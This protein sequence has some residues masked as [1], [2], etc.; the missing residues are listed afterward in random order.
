MAKK[1]NNIELFAG[2]GG[3]LDGFEQT[4]NYNLL[5]AVEWL[6]PQ[7]RTLINRLETKYGDQNATNKILNFDIQRTDELLKGWENDDEFGTSKGLD[8]L[9]GNNSVDVISGGPPCQAYSLAGR[10]RDTNGMK[11]D[12]RNFLFEAY[13]K[14]VA[15]YRPKVIVF[16][17]VE[18]IL[19]AIPTGEKIIDLIR[20]S[21]NDIDYEIINDLRQHAL[22]DLTEYGVPQKRKRVIIVGVRK[23]SSAID[24]QC[25]LR[26]F[27]NNILVSMKVSKKNTVKDALA[28]LPP[29][30]PLK[31]QVAKKAY[32]NNSC[33]N[34][35]YSRFHSKRD[36]GIFYE[37]A[38]DIEIGENK[39]SNADALIELYYERTGKKTNVHK[40]HV[41]RWDEPS[42]T[43]PA[44][45]KKDGLRHIHPDPK[46]RRSIT[47]RE[48]ARLQTFD[49]DFEFNEAM[50][51][52]FEMIGNAVPPLFAYKLGEVLPIFMDLIE[53][54]EKR[55]D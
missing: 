26:S 43:I 24:Y 33:I 38:N 8:N 4:G 32:E 27:Y 50:V 28:D 13:I 47:I 25:L 35:H 51:A 1:L 20:T 17:N 45:L 16:E 11:D 5:G 18:G 54:E 42:N 53:S 44:H 37:L 55:L 31:E 36:Q 14:I 6:K 30:Y 7:V 41:L 48:A 9:V 12:Y 21:F 2:V 39:Y 52:N 22:I 15:H 46:Q 3:L 10:I 49:D 29:I 23:D 40:Y 19:S 34:G